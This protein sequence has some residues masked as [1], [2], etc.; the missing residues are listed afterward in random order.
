MELYDAPLAGGSPTKLNRPLISGGY[1]GSFQVS[2]DSSQVV[3][4]ADQDTDGVDE[5]YVSFD[6]PD[7]SYLP[8]VLKN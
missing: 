7:R 4:R 3:Y 6:L 5:L 8:I 2:P 1:V